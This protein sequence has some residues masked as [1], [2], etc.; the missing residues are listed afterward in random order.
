V[1]RLGDASRRF[2]VLWGLWFISYT[3]GRYAEAREAGQRLLEEAEGGDDSGRLL[4]A[5]HAMWPTLL[6]IGESAAAVRYLER[7]IAIYRIEEHASQAFLYAGH[8]AGACC[9]Y[10]GAIIYWLLGS[11]DRGS[12]LMRDAQRIA[13]AVRS[14]FTVMVTLWMTSLLE[15]LR[16][17]REAA[18]RTSERM[19]EIAET[20]DIRHWTDAPLILPH[21]L[22]AAELSAADLAEIHRRLMLVG[23]A[24]WRRVFC[25]LTLTTLALEAGHVAE[26]RRAFES[27]DESARQGFLAPDVL[28]VEGELHLAN[29]RPDVDAA[30][31]CFAAAIDLARRRQEKSLELRATMSLFRLHRLRGTDKDARRAL[32]S[33]Y[34][35]FTEGFGTA[36]LLAAQSLLSSS[37]H[38]RR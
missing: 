4:E 29:G 35:S 23:N 34:S 31:R 10:Q 27:M 37:E 19:L 32:E 21:M 9:R 8:D 22:R 20:Y 16:G 38:P 6:A 7:G 17:E 14:P 18:A 12:A 15:S 11:P 24:V 30:E 2:P 13:E 1:E 25:L 3:S 28:R 26:A 33:L 5:H 36:D